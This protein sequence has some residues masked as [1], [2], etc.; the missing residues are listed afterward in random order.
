MPSYL[1]LQ[2]GFES[3]H[4]AAR[5]LVF[6][7]WVSLA[8]YPVAALTADGYNLDLE[9]PETSEARWSFIFRNGG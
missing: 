3:I 4:W 9:K 1:W 8:A 7:R 2:N 5:W 6:Q